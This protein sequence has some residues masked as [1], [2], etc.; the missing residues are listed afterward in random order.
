MLPA[1]CWRGSR[2]TRGSRTSPALWPRS[3]AYKA[4]TTDTCGGWMRASL[5]RKP[6][7]SCRT[8]PQIGLSSNDRRA[9]RRRAL[10]HRS[11]HIGARVARRSRMAL[12]GRVL[13]WLAGA[14]ELVFDAVPVRPRVERLA[15][16][17]R[18]AV[19]LPCTSMVQSSVRVTRRAGCE[20]S[21][22]TTGDTFEGSSTAA[23]TRVA[24]PSAN[25]SER[26]HVDQHSLDLVPTNSPARFASETRRRRFLC[27]ANRASRCR[28][29]IRSWFTSSRSRRNRMPSRL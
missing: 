8:A 19:G 11:L 10:P 26:E 12:P 24:C 7:L 20:R 23:N 16:K 21:A 4:F 13:D 28:R 18:A 3:L 2:L 25:V 1:S 9:R 6:R 27:S 15:R 22:S 17:L 5:R 14:D 29:K